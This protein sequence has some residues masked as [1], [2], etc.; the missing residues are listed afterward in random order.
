MVGVSDRSGS[1]A[2]PG[3]AV[4]LLGLVNSCWMT[5]AIS[6]A[7]DL[8]IPDLLVEGPRSS[9]ELADTIG[10]HEPFL[11]RL[12]V[13]LSTLDVCEARDDDMFALGPLGEVLRSDAPVSVRSW[14]LY[15]GAE[16]WP[17][18]GHLAEA[19]RTGRSGREIDS[20][21]REFEFLD[22]NPDSARRFD[23]AMVELTRLATPGIVAAYP[24]SGCRRVVDVGGGYGELLTAILDAHP[25]LTGILFDIPNTID[26]AHAHVEQSGVSD[27][28]ELVGGSFFESVPAGEDL[29]ILKSIIHDW[30]DERSREILRTCTEA[31]RDDSRLLVIE[32]IRPEQVDNSP[33]SQNI[34]R[35]DL[36]MLVALA[37]QERTES[38]FR[39]LLA[40]AG[41]QVQNV[42]PAAAGF[43]VIEASKR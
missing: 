2:G 12:L 24:F 35:A 8:G 32:R 18:W 16:M 10:A 42:I 6:A 21:V 22:A 41:L 25:S 14:A 34:A 23:E 37:A 4:R 17:V 40:S 3:E 19:V 9:R 33:G 36:T 38:E 26:E 20:G 39:E 31:M 43:S 7:A 1:Q 29:Y 15:S 5:A 30:D 27:R 28:C 13:A 11:R